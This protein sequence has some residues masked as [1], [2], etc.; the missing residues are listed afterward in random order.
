[1]NKKNT[2]AAA[3]LVG[4]SS[5]FGSV[6]EAQEKKSID[7]K[8]EDFKPKAGDIIKY[9]RYDTNKD[10]K[11]DEKDPHIADKRP[12]FRMYL[13]TRKNDAVRAVDIDADTMI[14]V[15]LK[16][17]KTVLAPSVAFI[18]EFDILNSEAMRSLPEAQQKR[19]KAAGKN[20]SV[21]RKQVAFMLQHVKTAHG[22]KYEEIKK[23]AKISERYFDL[24]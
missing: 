21:D 2:V 4:L 8:A 10:G 23:A 16:N 13:S 12:E 19:I 6:I 24:N 3:C 7:Q 17:G 15:K 1:M 22:V 20:R 14:A 11:I 9:Y 18:A 5:V